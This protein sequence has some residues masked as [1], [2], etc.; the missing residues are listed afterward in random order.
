MHRRVIPLVAI[1]AGIPLFVFPSGALAQD[2]PPVHP[3][4]IAAPAAFDPAGWREDLR[5]LA[6]ELPARHPNAFFRM[7]RASWDSAVGAIDARLP[8]M[9]RNQEIVALM[10]LA[11]MVLDGHT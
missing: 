9:T 5:L 11:A 1:A 2:H 7:S 10:G 4:A 3:T 6:R 8:D